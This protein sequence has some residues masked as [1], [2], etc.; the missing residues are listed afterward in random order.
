MIHELKTIR[1]LING[2]VRGWIS[3]AILGSC[4]IAGLDM[5]GVLAML[6]LMQLLTG[7]DPSH[8]ALGYISAAL[9]TKDRETLIL[10]VA[11]AV[12]VAFAS[13]SLLTIA[14][15]WWLLG[16]TTRL[17]AEA[18]TEMMRRYV[19]AP[20]WAH[21]SR[22]ISVV[23]RN[24]AT[25]VSQ[26]FGQVVLG[27]IGIVADLLTFLAILTVLVMVSP[28]AT[29]FTIAF[30]VPLGWLIQR[31]LRS[32]HL[33]IGRVITRSDLDAWN[34]L[35]PGLNGFREVRLSSSAG[36]FVGRFRRAKE[37]RANANRLASL[38]AELP[39]Y[40]LEM[41][42]VVC[43]A[44]IALLLFQTVSPEEALSVLGVFGAAAVRLLPTMNRA[45]ASLGGVRAGRV[46]LGILAREVDALDAA[47][48]YIERAGNGDR[49]AGDLVL[50][51]V[52]YRYQD[53]QVSVLK[54]ISTVITRGKTTAFVGSS[55]A[56]KSTLLDVLL[57]LLEPSSGKITC[58]GQSIFEDLPSWYTC[59]SLVPQDV[60]LLDDTLERNIAFGER[61]GHVDHERLMNAIDLA[62]L[63]PLVKEMPE[64]LNTRLGERGVRL[65]GGQR[66]RVGIARALY[67]RPQILVL[68]EATSALDNATEK[69]ISETIESLS[70][71]M[72]I[73]I[74]AHRLSTVKNADKV[75]F[76]SE[77]RITAEGSFAEVQEQ[78]RE[79][80]HLVALGKLG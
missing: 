35:M 79:F 19:L 6:P 37:D 71:S 43:I 69:K 11:V 75:V 24:I 73:V 23:Y 3:A 28:L 2:P 44:G 17:E 74:V 25:A 7:A 53:S 68:D 5:L 72:T 55:G 26:S 66:Q 18:A 76:M 65:S 30:F 58:G 4:V 46:G 78:S 64:G 56:G 45:V 80:A 21:R 38:V 27:L 70:G 77:G 42:F 60:F 31:G 14:F 33:E 29:L 32:R 48:Y 1:P 63:S 15:R 54:G 9:G 67:R 59:V 13:K 36:L 39:K 49:F 50:D 20:Y 16:R 12:G 52:E 40:I 51:N 61:R 22:E 10:A 57:G 41:G 47:G 8:G 34:A 62:Q